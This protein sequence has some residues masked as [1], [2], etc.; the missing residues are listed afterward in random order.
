[1]SD[2]M[3]MCERMVHVSGGILVVSEI[4]TTTAKFWPRTV[5][6]KEMEINFSEYQALYSAIESL[7]F[8]IIGIDFIKHESEATGGTPPEWRSYTPITGKRCVNASSKQLWSQLATASFLA[9][10]GLSYDLCLRIKYQLDS[11]AQR[12]KDLS[13]SYQQQLYAHC[14]KGKH[15]SGRRFQ[16][17]FTDI[18]YQKFHSF[19]F[20]ACILRDYLCEYVYLHSDDG[21]LVEAGTTVTTASKLQKVLRKQN[22]LSRLEVGLRTQMEDGGWIKA[23]GAYRDLVMHSAPINIANHNSWCIAQDKE[24]PHGEIFPSIKVPVPSDPAGL[25][26]KRSMRENFDQYLAEMEVIARASFEDEGANDCLDYAALTT[27]NLS[28]ISSDIAKLSPYKPVMTRYTQK[29]DAEVAEVDYIE[30]SFPV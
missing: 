12:L 27:T 4:G 5:H 10:N 30:M 21:K 13:A 6:G 3:P 16:D 9:K 15:T 2:Q 14:L 11:L 17:G 19:L 22:N 29:I 8:R 18:I 1:M 25:M 28:L 7:G 20:D 23:L 26:S 24:A